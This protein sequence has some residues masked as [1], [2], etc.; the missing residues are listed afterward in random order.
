MALAF[1]M[2]L[3]SGS[4][5]VSPLPGCRSSTSWVLATTPVK[6]AFSATT[7]PRTTRTLL[8]KDSTN[9]FAIPTV[10]ERSPPLVA[11]PSRSIVAVIA[12]QDGSSMPVGLSSVSVQVGTSAVTSGMEWRASRVR[13]I[14]CSR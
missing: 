5:W 13:D 1:C 4:D 3:R 9:S 11:W 10:C 7:S 8:A 6:A 2:T 12:A 14:T